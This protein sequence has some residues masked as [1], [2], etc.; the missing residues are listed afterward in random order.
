MDTKTYAVGFFQGAHGDKDTK[1]TIGD[2]LKQWAESKSPVVDYASHSY[3]LKNLEVRPRF[4]QG[5]FAK[6]RKKDIPKIGSNTSDSESQIPLDDEQGLVEKNHFLFYPKRNLL[7]FQSNRDA[8]THNMFGTYITEATDETT[9]FNAVLKLDSAKRLIGG[10]VKPKEVEVSFAVPQGSEVRKGK[11]RFTNEMISAMAG[12]GGMSMS[13]RIS[14]GR[15][16]RS[17]TS[18]L[19]MDVKDALVELTSIMDTSVARLKIENEEG[20]EDTV[21]L[22]ADRIKDTIKVSMTGRYPVTRDIFEKL[23][24]CTRGNDEDLKAVLG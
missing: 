19:T 11:K 3:R 9:I 8:S 1:V 7:V 2:V 16:S 12:A 13:A 15:G 22:I 23:R 17:S 20:I 21:D 4:I 5:E 10:G 6:L 14:L 18:Y 24:E